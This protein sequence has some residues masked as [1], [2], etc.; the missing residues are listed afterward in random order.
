[1]WVDSDS[2]VMLEAQFE[3]MFYYMSRVMRKPTFCICE[4]K[5][6]DQLTAKLISAFVF[7]TRIVQSLFYLNPKFQASNHLLCLYS[8]VCVDLV[9]DPEDQFSH[10]EAHIIVAGPMA[11]NSNPD[12]GLHCLP[13]PR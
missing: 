3:N 8:P 10:N 1:M 11:N 12:M 4:N 5:D 9:G 6:A 13:R 2:Q 7:A